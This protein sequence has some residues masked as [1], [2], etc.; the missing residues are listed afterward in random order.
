VVTVIDLSPCAHANEVANRRIV[1]QVG[2]R[3]RDALRRAARS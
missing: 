2:D 1:V 3:A